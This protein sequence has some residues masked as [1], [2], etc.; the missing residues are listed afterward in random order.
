MQVNVLRRHKALAAM[1]S[2]KSTDENA[3]HSGSSQIDYW[4]G[5]KVVLKLQKVVWHVLKKANITLLYDLTIP[6]LLFQEK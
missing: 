5:Y 6:L 4:Q 1:S 3:K 2:P